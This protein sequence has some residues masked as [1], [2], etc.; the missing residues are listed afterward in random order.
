MSYGV[1]ENQ[2]THN[3]NIDNHDKILVI[4]C[5]FYLVSHFYSIPICL[6]CKIAGFLC[7]LCFPYQWYVMIMLTVMK[8]DASAKQGTQEMECHAYS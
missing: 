7:I 2:H 5:H 4:M 6:N 1:R 3:L 8:G